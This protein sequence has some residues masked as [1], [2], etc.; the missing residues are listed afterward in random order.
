MVAAAL[1]AVAL[2]VERRE[3]DR[4][5]PEPA[6]LDQGVDA[7]RRQPRAVGEHGRRQTRRPDRPHL[8]DEPLVRRGLVVV[9]HEDGFDRV[10]VGRE[11]ADDPLVEL[12]RHEVV[13]A[14]GDR[15][16]AEV[17]GLIADRVRL[18]RDVLQTG[19]RAPARRRPAAATLP[20]RGARARRG[21]AGRSPACRR[22]GRAAPLVPRLAVEQRAVGQRVVEPVGPD[23]EERVD[24]ELRGPHGRGLGSARMGRRLAVFI[25]SFWIVV[26]RSR[27]GS[28][29][30]GAT[31]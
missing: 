17:A 14:R 6:H 22:A 1:A 18:E 30:L 31:G 21:R 28:V 9:D 24:L 4:E 13:L 5:E 23:V 25:S 8:I 19:T 26:F 3:V 15:H 20:R 11:L 7:V 10:A 12:G 29:S 16:R 2:A 27:S